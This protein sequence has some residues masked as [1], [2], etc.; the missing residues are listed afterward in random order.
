MKRYVMALLAVAVIV[1]FVRGSHMP[2]WLEI[3]FCWVGNIVV[4]GI[5]IVISA[6]GRARGIAVT[7]RQDNMPR[8]PTR[9]AAGT[10]A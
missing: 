7:G 3:L 4:V 2:L 9:P 8:I 6:V 5:A 10:G 1:V